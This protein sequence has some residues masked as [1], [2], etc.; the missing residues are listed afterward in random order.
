MSPRPINI[1]EK[2][3]AF[4]SLPDDAITDDPVA[5]AILGIGLDTFRRS[6]LIQKR[7]PQK[8]FSKRRV[9]RRVGDL[10]NLIR[11]AAAA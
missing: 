4:D 5:A 2:L 3:A 11:G 8:R 7:V 9:G 1:K 10:R 6:E